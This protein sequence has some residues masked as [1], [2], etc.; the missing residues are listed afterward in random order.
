MCLYPLCVA[1]ASG[2]SVLFLPIAPAVGP[3][4]REAPDMQRLCDCRD[5]RRVRD[6][7][8]DGLGSG[9]GSGFLFVGR[10]RQPPYRVF[11]SF[12]APREKKK[13]TGRQTTPPPQ[14]PVVLPELL[15]PPSPS[16][17]CPSATYTLH[18]QCPLCGK[19]RR[20]LRDG[21]TT[22]IL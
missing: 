4:C 21:S 13:R 8:R 7:K 18:R 14:P 1:L 15:H 17:F 5:P 16:L 6:L 19:K 3:G 10:D 2:L 12:A 22:T 9:S 20:I 11:P